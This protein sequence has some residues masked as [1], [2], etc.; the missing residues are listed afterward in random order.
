VCP[1]VL[2]E[3]AG[4]EISPEADTKKLFV[5]ICSDKGLC[6]GVHGAVNKWIKAQI[7]TLP[8][9]TD[10]KLC[11]VGD[12]ST[13][14]LS[15]SNAQDIIVT[16]SAVGKK[17]TLFS[18]SALIAQVRSALALCACCCPGHTHVSSYP[19]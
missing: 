18:E 13:A 3:K 8:E 19:V 5:A 4:A 15:R 2:T 16:A 1:T 10:Y 7:L 12:K 6:G 9:G 17:P 14:V 11:L